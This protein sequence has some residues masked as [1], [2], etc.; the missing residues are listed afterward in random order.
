MLGVVSA[1]EYGRWDRRPA[2]PAAT[3]SFRRNDDEVE[4]GCHLEVSPQCFS[5]RRLRPRDEEQT[6]QPETNEKARPEEGGSDGTVE[7]IGG[8]AERTNK[9][10]E[11]NESPGN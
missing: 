1:P 8:N 9:Y 11:W 3:G 6:N 4:I 5:S 7:G 2:T 10:V